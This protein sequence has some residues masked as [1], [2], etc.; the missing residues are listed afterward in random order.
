MLFFTEFKKSLTDW[1]WYKQIAQGAPTLRIRYSF[2]LSLIHALAIVV[3]FTVMLYT[4]L[5]PSLKSFVNNRVPE[6][7]TVT[8]KSGVLSLDK[9]APYRIAFTDD[10]RK[11]NGNISN[12]LVIDPDA[13][14]TLDAPQK[15]DTLIFATKDTVIVKRE[16]GE[17]R[18]YPLK[19]MPDVTL[20][21]QSINDF[22]VK[23]EK[24]AWFLPVL[25]TVVLMVSIFLFQLLMCAAAGA[26]IYF[27]RKMMSKPLTFGNSFSVALHAYTFVF[28][29]QILLV[30]VGGGFG[31]F[32]SALITA[33]LGL[34]FIHE[35]Q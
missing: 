25:L 5:I 35:T 1:A 13:Q 28:V 29:I 3:A 4:V 8:V 33:A 30:F 18:A 20:S 24:Y 17:V 9:P 7:V 19:D 15:N 32:L 27:F 2:V 12:F 11:K 16:S 23:A 31:F 14:A 10:E 22:I 26:L 6:E 34:F 21:R